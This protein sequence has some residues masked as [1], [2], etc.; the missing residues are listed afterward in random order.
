MNAKEIREKRK[1]LGITQKKLAEM[2][3]VST[4]TIN[5]YENGKEIPST[6]IKILESILSKN[7]SNIV[8]EPDTKYQILFGDNKHIENIKSKIKEHQ[9]IISLASGDK[10]LIEYHT[11]MINLLKIQIQLI[12]ETRKKIETENNKL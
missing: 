10:T 1:E 5:G 7:T 4:Q 12:L 3:G 9:K 6:K 8:L 2:L 11:E